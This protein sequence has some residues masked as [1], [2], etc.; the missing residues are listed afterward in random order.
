MFGAENLRWCQENG[1]ATPGVTRPVETQ[2]QKKARLAA[3]LFVLVLF[4]FGDDGG[5]Q[6]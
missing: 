3:G 2:E 6:S 5:P 1:S 4:T